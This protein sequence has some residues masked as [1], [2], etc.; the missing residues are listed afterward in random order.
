V[1]Q[2]TLNIIDVQ[3]NLRGRGR[4]GWSGSG[5]SHCYSR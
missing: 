3:R 4:F 2:K 1:R 5:L